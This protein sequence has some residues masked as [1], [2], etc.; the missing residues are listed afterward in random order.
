[1]KLAQDH[2]QWIALV[3]EMLKVSIPFSS[4]GYIFV[5]STGIK[6]EPSGTLKSLL[7]AGA[8]QLRGSEGTRTL[9]IMHFA[10]RRHT[11][12]RMQMRTR[13]QSG[14]HGNATLH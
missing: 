13:L 12:P 2:V 4:I 5:A 1:V 14:R 11:K 7:T 9:L 10:Q 8:E 3:L 6:P